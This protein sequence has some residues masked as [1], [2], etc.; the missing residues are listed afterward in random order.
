MRIFVFVIG[1][2]L[3]SDALS[4]QAQQTTL[5]RIEKEMLARISD[6]A[7]VLHGFRLDSSEFD[8]R[9]PMQGEPELIVGPTMHGN[10]A[11]AVGSARI[12]ML[13][14]ISSRAEIS[15]RARYDMRLEDRRG[16]CV[17]VH[18]NVSFDSTLVRG[19][20][21][22]ERCQPLYMAEVIRRARRIAR[23]SFSA[24]RLDDH[25]SAALAATGTADVYFDSVVV[26]TK[27]MTL[28]ASYPDPITHDVAID[29]VRAGLGLGEVHSWNM[30]R[31]SAALRV[32]TTLHLNGEWR[33]NVKR[34][35]IPI[36][37]TFDLAKSWPLFEVILRVPK[38]SSNP[39]GVAWTY[40][41]EKLG[42]F[43]NT[44]FNSKD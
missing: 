37:S 31:Q 26:T 3:M 44:P 29:S 32:D 8:L 17:I 12:E 19:R 38:T 10:D 25:W 28:R 24:G 30:V 1:I 11:L 13:D 18:Q 34:F 2:A 42:F 7:I 39:L 36:D 40:A 14:S 5:R 20:R 35:V 33:R 41:H 43:A 9:L 21:S 16:N 22:V 23:L 6:R 4:A 15:S 27:T